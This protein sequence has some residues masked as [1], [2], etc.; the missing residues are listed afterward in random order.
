MG[1][2]HKNAVKAVK[3]LGEDLK[4][5][6]VVCPGSFHFWHAGQYIFEYKPDVV[7][8]YHEKDVLKAVIWEIESMWP[9][10]K[11][12]CG[13]AVLASLIGTRNAYCFR[14]RG[15]P[16]RKYGETI[17]DDERSEWKG[18]NIIGKKGEC[19]L[20]P[21]L[22]AFFLLVEEYETKRNAKPYLNVIKSKT[23]LFK[24]EPHVHANVIHLATGLS[25]SSMKERLRSDYYLHI[26]K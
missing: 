9:D 12:I 10:T 5:L 1:Q 11:R 13:D 6:E 21:Q 15:S 24:K 16:C 3:K 17:R 23:P 14:P 4:Y 20:S 22:G 18:G 25:V 2:W 7:W 19:R 26:W 8:L